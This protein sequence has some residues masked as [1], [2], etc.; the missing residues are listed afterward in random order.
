MLRKL[1]LRA[2]ITSVTVAT[3][4]DKKR[5]VRGRSLIRASSSDLPL[6]LLLSPPWKV[7]V[8]ESYKTGYANT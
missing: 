6:K 8:V 1:R 3:S 5:V 4:V 7:L 2:S